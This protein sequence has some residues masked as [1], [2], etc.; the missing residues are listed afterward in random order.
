MRGL[1]GPGGAG[2]LQQVTRLMMMLMPNTHSHD[3]ADTELSELGGDN[4]TQAH[5]RTH[6]RG[7]Q[8]LGRTD[9][10]RKLR[11]KY[12]ARGRRAQQRHTCVTRTTKLRS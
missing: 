1:R 9:G 10:D 8:K 5:V 4:T 6:V 12:L 3:T 2:S 11:R 7:E